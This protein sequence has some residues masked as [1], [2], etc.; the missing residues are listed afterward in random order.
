MVVVAHEL[1][2]AREVADTAVLLDGGRGVESG[3]PS[4]VLDD[5]RE[6]RTRRLLGTRRA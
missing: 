1:A 6:G 2:S 4:R 3:P 5:P